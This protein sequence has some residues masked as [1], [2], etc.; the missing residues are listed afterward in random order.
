M[1]RGPR[2]D[3]PGVLHHVMAR[4]LDRQVIFRDTWDRDDFVRRLA[5]VAQAG[6]VII[7]AWALLPNHFHL[8]LRTGN[9]PL[10]RSMRSLLTPLCGAPSTG[11]TGGVVTSFRTGTSRSWWRRNCISWSSCVTCT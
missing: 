4:G 9:R 8:L 7:H 1:P 10:A 3:A 2:L 11:D 5:E 6:A